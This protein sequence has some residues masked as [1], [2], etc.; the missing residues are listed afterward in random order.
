MKSDLYLFSAQRSSHLPASCRREM[1]PAALVC[2]ILPKFISALGRPRAAEAAAA[3]APADD[4]DARAPSYPLAAAPQ[5]STPLRL[6][7]A[8]KAHDACAAAALDETEPLAC[9]ERAARSAGLSACLSIGR[10]A[11]LSAARSA[12]LSAPA[13]ALFSA[14][15]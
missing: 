14:A 10:S 1:T 8:G 7:S 9:G 15:T 6:E 12:R 11:V 13:S 2:S 3:P 5:A 4:E